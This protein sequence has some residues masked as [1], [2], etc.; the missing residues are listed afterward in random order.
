MQSNQK[1]S[2]ITC[3]KHTHCRKRSLWFTVYGVSF[4]SF[5][6]HLSLSSPSGII[7]QAYPWGLQTCTFESKESKTTLSYGGLC[8]TREPSGTRPPFNWDAS[9]SPSRSLWLR[10]VWVC[11]MGSLPWMMS[12]SRTVRCPQQ[13]RSAPRSRI[14][15]AR[16]PRHVW[17]TWSSVTLWMIVGMDPMRRDVV[18]VSNIQCW[19]KYSD[20]GTLRKT[21]FIHQSLFPV[22]EFYCLSCV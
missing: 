16:T 7:T 3:R 17:S 15:T 11:S 20:L 9:P 6:I 5:S 22:F 4:S 8:T 18:S 10:S 12:R 14:S 2:C 21:N 19:K 13:W 1:P